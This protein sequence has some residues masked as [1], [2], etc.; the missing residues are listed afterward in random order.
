MFRLLKQSVKIRRLGLFGDVA[1]YYV[2]SL[3]V[4]VGYT[5]QRETDVNFNVPLSK[6]IVHP[7]VKIKKD[8]DNI[9]M[10]G[11]TTKIYN[12]VVRIPMKAFFFTIAEQPPVGRGLLI[13]E[14][15]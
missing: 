14:N 11:T 5:V 12:L 2:K 15:T 10:H 8:S 9:K 13:V 3:V 4:Y 7:L 6:H 1:A